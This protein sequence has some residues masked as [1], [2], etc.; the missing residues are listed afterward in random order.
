MAVKAQYDRQRRDVLL[1]DKFKGGKDWFSVIPHV[2]L[3]F[4]NGVVSQTNVSLMAT[5]MLPSFEQIRSDFN[6]VNPMYISKGNP[7]LQKATNYEMNVLG[8]YMLGKSHFLKVSL[9]ESHKVNIKQKSKLPRICFFTE[10]LLKK[11]QK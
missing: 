3:V 10:I 6:T 9:K 8:V 7:D 1:P 4:K 11:Y 2:S 5:P